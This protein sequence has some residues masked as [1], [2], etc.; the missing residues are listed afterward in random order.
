MSMPETPVA[1]ILHCFGAGKEREALVKV[2]G[3]LEAAQAEMALT[4][5]RFNA[6]LQEHLKLSDR[7]VKLE[8][9]S[10]P[11]AKKNAD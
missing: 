5:K 9:K 3:A 2:A 11:K 8:G 1:Q 4:N 6:L 7:V 10:E